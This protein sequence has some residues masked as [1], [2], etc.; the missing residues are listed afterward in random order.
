[1]VAEEILL[2]WMETSGNYDHY[3]CATHPSLSGR[4]RTSGVPK[5]AF[6]ENIV[7]YLAQH[8][9]IKIARQVRTKIGNYEKSWKNTHNILNRT[10][11]GVTDEDLR[12]ITDKNVL[13]GKAVLRAF[14]KSNNLTK[15]CFSENRKV[16]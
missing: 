13:K 9:I 12:E 15:F 7:L 11:E 5:V 3:R 6:S 1:M 2:L 16:A 8:D 4:F 14:L 10:G